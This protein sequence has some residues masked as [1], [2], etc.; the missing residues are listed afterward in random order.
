M[1][2]KILT[3]VFLFSSFFISVNDVKVV[4]VAYAMNDSDQQVEDVMNMIAALPKVCTLS[5]EDNVK[6]ARLAYD[7][8][9][10][11]QKVNVTNLLDLLDRENQIANLYAEVN[12]LVGLIESLPDENNIE[13]TDEKKINDIINL[14][15]ELDNLQKELVS[16]YS[17]IINLSNKINSIYKSIEELTKLINSLPEIENVNYSIYS[18]LDNIEIIYNSLTDYQKNQVKN[19]NKY[20]EIKNLLS[21][22]DIII[23]SINKIP[24]K[25]TLDS[26]SLLEGIENEYLKLTV[27]QRTLVNNYDEFKKLYNSILEAIEFN[28]LIAEFVDYIDLDNKYL[29]DYLLNKYEKFN[30]NQKVFITNYEKIIL[31]I[32]EIEKEEEYFLEAKVIVDLINK[33]PLEITL[34]DKEE[35]NNIRI[36]Y[37]NLFDKSKKYVSNYHLLLQAEATILNLENIKNSM[38]LDNLYN[39]VEDILNDV[40]DVKDNI[41][42]NEEESKLLIE[43]IKKFIEETKNNEAKGFNKY[44]IIAIGLTS[45]FVIVAIIYIFS[46]G[47][48]K[49]NIDKEEY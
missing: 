22:I 5:D 9:L 43:D 46:F 14:Y 39:E 8:L 16:N 44:I 19:I 26:L 42:Q 29:L 2:Y 34:E 36:K 33:L 37:D 3:F 47:R 4:N 25:L 17:K 13:L 12:Y 30:D 41:L 10:P 18:K 32:E 11:Y 28:E 40:Q 20:L 7:N 35:I 24:S 27:D 1:R 45:V 38:E 21:R 48:N 6:K 23:E 31:L 15:N 49:I